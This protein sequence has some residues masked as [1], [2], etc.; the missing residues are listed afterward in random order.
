MIKIAYKRPSRDQSPTRVVHHIL[1]QESYSPKSYSQLILLSDSYRAMEVDYYSDIF[2]INISEYRLLPI[3]NYSLLEIIRQQFDRQFITRKEKENVLVCECCG[4]LL[5]KG[6]KIKNKNKAT[7]DHK[8]PLIDEPDWFDE[9][10]LGILCSKC[11]NDKD[12]MPYTDWLILHK[13]F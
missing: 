1:E 3:S 11:N 9:D 8:V 6:D 7:V 2:D 4:S 12:H 13:K 10:N 5:S